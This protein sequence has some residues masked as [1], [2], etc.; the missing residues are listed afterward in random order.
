MRRNNDKRLP[1]FLSYEYNKRV[2]DEKDFDVFQAKNSNLYHRRSCGYLTRS[3]TL[4]RMSRSSAILNGY[5]KCNSCMKE[6]IDTPIILWV[7][8]VAFIIGCIS[9]LL[10]YTL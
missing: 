5:V 9:L 10:F 8:L 7:I 6:P 3:R 1:E 2:I 4:K